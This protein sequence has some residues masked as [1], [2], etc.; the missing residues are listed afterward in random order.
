MESGS[1]RSSEVIRGND[2]GH[3]A[4]QQCRQAC[5]Q[6]GLCFGSVGLA[7]RNCVRV[8][9]RKRAQGFVL[10]RDRA[11]PIGVDCG[12]DPIARCRSPRRRR[13]ALAHLKKLCVSH[14]LIWATRA[15]LYACIM[16]ADSA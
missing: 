8:R 16:I 10:Q 1:L 11:G 5:A 13:I 15:A 14:L 2:D 3:M 4:R 6:Q 12:E 9:V 7:Q